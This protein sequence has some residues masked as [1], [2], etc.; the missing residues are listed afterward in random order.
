VR[1]VRGGVGE[2]REGLN[3]DNGDGLNGEAVN[4][5][6]L[7]NQRNGGGGAGAGQTAADC[8]TDGVRPT[9][10]GAHCRS[11]HKPAAL[12]AHFCSAYTSA[13]RGVARL[14]CVHR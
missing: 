5:E 13:P 6:E 9:R 2:G 1:A 4:A 8:S 14:E 12:P 7:K 3:G 10:V 11:Q